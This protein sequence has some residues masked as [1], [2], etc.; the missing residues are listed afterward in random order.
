M[1]HCKCTSVKNRIE[2][3]RITLLS[4]QQ[5]MAIV[6]SIVTILYVPPLLSHSLTLGQRPA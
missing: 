4:T 3:K 2:I 1:Q 5:G 6:I